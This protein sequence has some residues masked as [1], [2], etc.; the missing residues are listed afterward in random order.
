MNALDLCKKVFRIVTKRVVGDCR[1]LCFLS[2]SR[3]ATSLFAVFVALCVLEI[4]IQCTFCGEL[5]G[6]S[7]NR[8]RSEAPDAW[9]EI[10]KVLSNFH[11]NNNGLTTKSEQLVSEDNGRRTVQRDEYFERRIGLTHRLFTHRDLLNKKEI[12]RCGNPKYAFELQRV[13]NEWVVTGVYPSVSRGSPEESEYSEYREILEPPSEVRHEQLPIQSSVNNVTWV[14]DK[15]KILDSGIVKVDARECIKLDF[16]FPWV[17]YE[18]SGEDG[19][20]RATE[21]EMTGTAVFDAENHWTLVSFT[22]GRPAQDS[23]AGRPKFQTENHFK[24]EQFID[25]V[26]VQT[27][28]RSAGRDLS[29]NSI[30]R[31]VTY[32]VKYSFEPLDTKEFTLTAFGFPEPEF[33]R[34]PYW[35]YT[36]LAGLVLVFVGGCVYYWGVRLR[37]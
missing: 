1:T 9:A 22:W 27:F 2:S 31:E 30:N 35:M 14:G 4:S 15:I 3:R 37:R 18:E 8:F 32:Q 23:G 34:P 10:N 16:K 19:R 12:L 5:S 24:Y 21:V 13:S 17:V 28:R 7:L 25:G 20:L 11:K 29:R 36:S 33:V 26:P 6:Q